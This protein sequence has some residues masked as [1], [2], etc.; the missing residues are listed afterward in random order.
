MPMTTGKLMLKV[1]VSFAIVTMMFSTVNAAPPT[2]LW[3][4]AVPTY[5]IDLSKDGN[6]VALVTPLADSGQLRFYG[7]GSGTPIWTWSS[8]ETLFSVG[9]SAD[10][11]CVVAGGEPHVYFWR[12]ARSLTGNPSPTW[13]SENLVGGIYRRCL[14]ISNDGNYVVACGTGRWV[15]YWSNAKG[16]SGNDK[17]VT[18]K[19]PEF[20]TVECVDLSSDGDYVAAGIV[21]STLGFAAAYW[22]N[23]RTLTGNDRNPDWKSPAPDHNVVDIATSDDGNYVAAAAEM[24]FSVHYWANAKSLTGNPDHTWYY[25]S[26]ISFNCIDMSSDGNAVIAGS[27][28]GV[29][30][31]VFPQKGEVAKAALGATL[32]GAVYFWSG[33]K[34]LTGK[35]QNPTWTYTTEAGIHDVAIDDAG[36]YMAADQNIAVPGQVQFFNSGGNLL[37]SYPIEFA[38]KVSISGDGATLAVGTATPRTGYLL[39]TGY[40]SAPRAVGGVTIPANKLEILTPYL[41]LA[42]L[43]IAAVSTVAVVKKRR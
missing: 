35:P 10:G 27:G 29:P 13:S 42:G 2:Q 6:Y 4:D 23:A 37:W 36:S 34:G 33:A 20:P 7:R 28:G 32:G 38:D 11:D 12:N 14:D 41:A 17:P 43:V 25:G 5:D 9:I 18:W 3:S 31:N 19:S 24:D 16:L 40:T 26:G 1:L 22:K 15:F 30:I 8:S 39:S 21:D